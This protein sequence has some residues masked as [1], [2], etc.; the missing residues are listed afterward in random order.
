MGQECGLPALLAAPVWAE[1]SSFNPAPPV[2]PQSAQE[3]E[4]ANLDELVG[5]LYEYGLLQPIL[6]G[7]VRDGHEVIDGQR[8]L[9]A[10]KHWG[11]RAS[12]RL[13]AASRHIC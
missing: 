5:S 10:A 13:S 2:S 8:R 4:L 3:V 1:L 7:R 6:I 9:A 12:P 11:G